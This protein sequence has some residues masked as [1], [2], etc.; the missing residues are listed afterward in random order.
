MGDQVVERASLAEGCAPAR[1]T[2][3]WGRQLL[4]SRSA[5]P[6][7]LGYRRDFDP[8]LRDLE[9]VCPLPHHLGSRLQIESVVVGGADCIPGSVGE[10]QLDVFVRAPPFVQDGGC[11]PA[12]PVSRHC[13]LEAHPL[14]R[15][16]DRVVA[17][18]LGRVK[19][20]GEEPLAV[21]SQS[22]QQIQ[23]FQRLVPSGTM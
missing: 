13:A 14:E 2:A 7:S 5:K 6:R 10:L 1:W 8:T 16:Q 9:K 19:V 17:H 21:V 15:L 12:E 4:A 20:A 3:R 18:L 22:P 11:Q 23:N